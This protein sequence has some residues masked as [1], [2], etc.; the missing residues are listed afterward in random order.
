MRQLSPLRYFGV[1]A[2]ASGWI[3]ILTSMILNPWFSIARNALSDMGA[4]GVKHAWVFNSG[5]MISGALAFL[6][7][8]YLLLALGSRLELLAS[9][10]MILAS[11][12]LILIGLF[13]EGTYPHFFVSMEFFVLMGVSILLFG[14]AFL[15]SEARRYGICFMAMAVAGFLA[16]IL[17]PWPLRGSLEVFEISLMTLWSLL[18]LRLV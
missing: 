1:C 8:A 15:M 18:M 4:I 17:A 7:S 3:T 10:I 6:Y 13:P 14:V 9:S 5:L 2:A 12:H 11:I 16:A